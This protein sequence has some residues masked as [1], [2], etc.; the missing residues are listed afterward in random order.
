MQSP[1]GQREDQEGDFNLGGWLPPF[2]DE[3]LGEEMGKQMSEPFDLLLGRKTFEIFAS[4]WPDH[5]EEGAEIN[6]AT[7]YVVSRSLKSHSWEKSIFIN[8][9]FKKEI[10]DIKNTNGPDLQVHGSSELIQF[11][12]KEELV[13]EMWLKIFPIILGKG[14]RIFAEGINPSKF[15]LE[16][17]KKSDSG[18]VLAKY[19]KAG[20]LEF[21]SV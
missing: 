18:V 4:Y 6:A 20:E 2:F 10:T 21:G 1:G 12:L 16:S 19:S 5:P 9:N 15:N 8:D 14:K 11:L 3:T 7:K 13:D 17:L